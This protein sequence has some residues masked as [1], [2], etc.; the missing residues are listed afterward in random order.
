MTTIGGMASAAWNLSGKTGRRL[1]KAH[2]PLVRLVQRG[3]RVRE[4]MGQRGLERQVEHQIAAVVDGD[5]PIVAGPWLAEVGYEILYWIPFLRWFTHAYRVA[6]ER[7][8]VMSRGGVASWYQDLAG[9][10]IEI[11]DYVTPADFARE[12]TARRV[13]TDAGGQKPSS[14]GLFDEQLLD[15]VRVETGETDVRV[16]HPSLMFRL[17]NQFRLGNQAPDFLWRHTSFASMRLDPPATV[18]LP[19]RYAVVKFH[20]GHALPASDANRSVVRAAVARLARRQ[21]VVVLES[22]IAVDEHDDFDF[23]GLANV[24]RVRNRLTAATNLDVQSRVIA[25]ADRYVG[26]CGGLAWLAPFLG[27]STTGVYEHDKLLMTHLFVARH[28]YRTASAAPF[29]TVDL[30]ALGHLGLVEVAA[31]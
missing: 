15:Y 7:L 24:H 12:N 10:Y 19:E 6:P 13:E 11:F 21:P 5:A 26:T 30:R 1:A 28:A 16:F 17:F 29:A 4:H 25:G 20:A 22:G 2:H 27:V 14:V 9:R 18:P 3:R 31:R 8:I 23:D